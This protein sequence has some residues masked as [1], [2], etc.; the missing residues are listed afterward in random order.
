M[1][2][3]TQALYPDPIEHDEQRILPTMPPTSITSL[4]DSRSYLNYAATSDPKDSGSS[5]AEALLLVRSLVYTYLVPCCSPVLCLLELSQL[6]IDS[7]EWHISRN[8]SCASGYIWHRSANYC[9]RTHT[10]GTANM[11]SILGDDID[12]PF[13]PSVSRAC[14]I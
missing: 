9:L 3:T 7:S 10:S 5:S 2:S 1:S 13:C 4:P 11:A 8:P 6:S 12:V 14:S